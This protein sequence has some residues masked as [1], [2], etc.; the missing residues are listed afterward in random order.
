MHV[1]DVLTCFIYMKQCT[2]SNVL[3]NM[4]IKLLELLVCYYSITNVNTLYSVFVDQ[5][6]IEL[7]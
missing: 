5:C 4:A 6:F 7:T 3:L 1:C 2:I